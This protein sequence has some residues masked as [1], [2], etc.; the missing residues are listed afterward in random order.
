MYVC[1]YMYTC[2]CA[3]I[4]IH[5]YVWNMHIHTYIYIC[6]YIYMYVYMNRHTYTRMCL[7]LCVCVCVFQGLLLSVVL[8]TVYARIRAQYI[9]TCILFV[10]T[11]TH[12]NVYFGRTYFVKYLT[13]ELRQPCT[14]HVYRKRAPDG[15]QRI[16]QKKSIYVWPLRFT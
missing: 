16:S 13:H 7:Y 14:A 11:H 4:F 15:T 2:V 1:V 8:S 6:I 12:L 10:C 5:I 3:Y 9:Y